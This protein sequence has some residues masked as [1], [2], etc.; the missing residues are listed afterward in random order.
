[1][2]HKVIIKAEGKNASGKTYFLKKIKTFLE[3]E[4]FE[5]NDNSLKGEHKIVIV[6]EY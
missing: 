4:G 3:K 2:K 6:N 1:M 5:V